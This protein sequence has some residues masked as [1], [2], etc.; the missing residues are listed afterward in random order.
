MPRRKIS[1][2]QNV[3]WYLSRVRGLF[4]DNPELGFP[5][6]PA[7]EVTIVATYDSTEFDEHVSSCEFR[8]FVPADVTDVRA[9]EREAYRRLRRQLGALAASVPDDA[10]ARS[11]RPD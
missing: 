11:L 4:P 5:A 8:V 10:A 3:Q 1:P 2:P 7:R 9:I 6:R